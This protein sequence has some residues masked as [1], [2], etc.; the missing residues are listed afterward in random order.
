M[1]Y[2]KDTR[3]RGSQGQSQIQH[4][5]T[6]TFELR[7]QVNAVDDPESVTYT[8]RVS[9]C[10]YFEALLLTRDMQGMI[11]RIVKKD[12]RSHLVAIIRL[13]DKTQD[14]H[15]DEN[16]WVV[17]NDFAVTNVTE[18]EALSFAGSWKVSVPSS[19]C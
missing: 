13:K 12:E 15:V 3:Q 8:L 18:D 4:F 7:G 10:P 6:P 5:L 1:R 19:V 2:W 16:E 14:P 17:F 11:A 9:P